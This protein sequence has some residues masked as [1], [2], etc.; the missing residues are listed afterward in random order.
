MPKYHIK[1]D[2]TPGVCR[3]KNACPLGGEESHFP[4]AEAAQ[5][6]SQ[7][8]MEAEYGVNNSESSEIEQEQPKAE[9]S[10][11]ERTA[12]LESAF[13]KMEADPELSGSQK[14]EYGMYAEIIRQVAPML[15]SVDMSSAEGAEIKNLFDQFEDVMKEANYM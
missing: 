6:E 11:T 15:D 12:N 1:K 10:F 4:T 5:E 3:A 14:A 13:Q 2:G 7:R 8:R 9:L